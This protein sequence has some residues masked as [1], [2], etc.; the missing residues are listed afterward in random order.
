MPADQHLF[1]DKNCTIACLKVHE[2]KQTQ[3]FNAPLKDHITS[4]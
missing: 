1:V 3:K 4:M 2:L